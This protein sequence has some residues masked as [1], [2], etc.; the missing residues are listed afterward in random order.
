LDQGQV[1]KPQGKGVAVVA[2]DL[3]RRRKSED[4]MDNNSKNSKSPVSLPAPAGKLMKMRLVLNWMNQKSK[5]LMNKR[6]RNFVLDL[7]G[8]FLQG[9]LESM[10]L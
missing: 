2:D 3:K 6:A 10:D 1:E 7:L 9:I 5:V 8:R 4:A